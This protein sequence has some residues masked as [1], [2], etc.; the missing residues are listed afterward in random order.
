MIESDDGISDDEIISSNNVMVDLTLPDVQNDSDVI[1]IE[2]DDDISNDETISSNNN[3]IKQL[4][5]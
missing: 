5:I 3:Y 2:S 4:N 1:M